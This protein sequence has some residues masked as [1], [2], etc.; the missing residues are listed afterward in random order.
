MTKPDWQKA[1]DYNYMSDYTGNYA[2]WAWEFLRR[3]SDYRT[4][5]KAYL[6][7]ASD[8]ELEFGVDWVNM[9]KARFYDPP[10]LENET[11]DKWVQRCELDLDKRPR[12][13]HLHKLRGETFYLDGMFDPGLPYH[14]DI[15]FLSPTPFPYIANKL[16]DLDQFIEEF[17]VYDVITGEPTD[18]ITGFGQAVGVVVFTLDSNLEKQLTLAG[19]ELVELRKI[20]QLNKPH[21]PT[22]HPT[23]RIY[24]RVLDA[25]I[26]DPSVNKIT[27]VFWPEPGPDE[28]PISKAKETVKQARQWTWPKQYQRLLMQ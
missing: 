26:D 21:L 24:L 4:A 3:G 12:P 8:L 9:P 25:L 17:D 6:K 11:W 10:R 14:E 5:Y 23:W 19:K 27:S 20:K 18:V 22:E 13:I 28:D 1:A 7:E 16:D 2:A 15:V